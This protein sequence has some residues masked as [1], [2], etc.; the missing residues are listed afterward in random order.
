LVR[1]AGAAAPAPVSEGLYPFEYRSDALT[2][3]NTHGRNT[4]SA[5][6]LLHHIQQG[7]G[8]PRTGATE[9]MAQGNGAAV[10]VDLLIHLVEQLEVL[11]YRQGLGC[12][13]FVQ[14]DII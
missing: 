5:T 10:Q 11:E 7:A 4:D 2:Q 1:Q 3:T 6:L 8:D 13:G 9:G 12:E 14:F